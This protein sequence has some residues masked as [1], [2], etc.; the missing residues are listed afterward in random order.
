MMAMARID[1]RNGNLRRSQTLFAPAL[2]PAPTPVPPQET[3]KLQ[4]PSSPR[5]H[6]KPRAPRPGQESAVQIAPVPGDAPLGSAPGK[7]DMHGL[8]M[9]SS[10]DICSLFDSYLSNHEAYTHEIT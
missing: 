6:Q 1:T 3:S 8:I 10:K 4:A 2:G 7:T 5:H 9:R